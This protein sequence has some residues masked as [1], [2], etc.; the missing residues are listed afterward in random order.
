MTRAAT[1][2]DY[3]LTEARFNET[4]AV[5]GEM[6]AL[7]SDVADCM[8]EAP[9]RFAEC[10]SAAEW[11][12][13]D[14]LQSMAGAWVDRRDELMRVWQ[15]LSFEDKIAIGSLPDFD[16]PDPLSPLV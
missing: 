4:G 6:A 7:L 5:L 11:P 13:F 16:A 8:S 12:S 9:A 3:R 14:K 2:D 10:V 1:V 15:S